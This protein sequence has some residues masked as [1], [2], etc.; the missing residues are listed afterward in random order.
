MT[1]NTKEANPQEE[2]QQSIPGKPLAPTG[3]LKIVEEPAVTKVEKPKI[4]P[5]IVVERRPDVH[6]TGF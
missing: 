6:Y 2:T 5:K 4:E 3:A 1:N